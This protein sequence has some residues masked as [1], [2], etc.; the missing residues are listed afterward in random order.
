M[1]VML[2]S[3][4]G[5]ALG[6]GTIHHEKADDKI[7][8]HETPKLPRSFSKTCLQHRSEEEAG[9]WQLFQLKHE[10]KK[11]HGP[12]HVDEECTMAVCIRST[13]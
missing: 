6:T 11:E 7:R 8:V 1:C 5:E 10:I 9:V 13:G 4:T 12:V 2:M 3:L